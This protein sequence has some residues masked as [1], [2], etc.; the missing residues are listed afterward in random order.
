[1]LYKKIS[2]RRG[3]KKPVRGIE[4]WDQ[5]KN[6]FTIERAKKILK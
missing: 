2:S 6:R 5:G 4:G 1:V 3:K